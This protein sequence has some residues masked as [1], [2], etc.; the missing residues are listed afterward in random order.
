MLY[1]ISTT[2]LRLEANVI[3]KISSLKP[4]TSK[5]LQQMQTVVSK[6]YFWCFKNC[7]TTFVT[8]LTHTYQERYRDMAR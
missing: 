8:V 7:A 3:K 5:Q 6:K 4:I 2:Y 1:T